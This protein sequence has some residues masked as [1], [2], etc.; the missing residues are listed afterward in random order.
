MR[1]RLLS[2][3]GETRGLEHTFED[4][5]TIGRGASN[6][7]V[8]D[9]S[10]V[11]GQHARIYYDLDQDCYMVEDLASLNGTRVDGVRAKRPM[12]LERLHVLN[13][14]RV[15]EFIFQPLPEKPRVGASEA[16]NSEA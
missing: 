5:V 11:S 1:A 7:L 14:G 8:L 10:A 2:Q 3:W 6:S 4:E 13:F 12:R 16:L 9:S 15:C